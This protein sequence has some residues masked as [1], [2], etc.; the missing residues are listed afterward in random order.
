MILGS[1]A[2]AGYTDERGQVLL[3][4]GGVVR[5][6]SA[7]SSRSVEKMVRKDASKKKKKSVKKINLL[8]LYLCKFL[9][10]HTIKIDYWNFKRNISF[11][12]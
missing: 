2:F 5:G 6:D 7:K 12:Y 10:F 9:A 1:L 11:C 8:L 3:T 4:T